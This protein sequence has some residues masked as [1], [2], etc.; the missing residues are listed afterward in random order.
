VIP[1]YVS[2][3]VTHPT[4]PAA[5][6]PDMV[7]SAMRVW[8]RAD[9][10]IRFE[11]LGTTQALPGLPFDGKNVIGYGA[12]L[13]PALVAG[14]TPT[15]F[16]QAGD[17]NEADIV[18]SPTSPW[19]WQSC[20]QQDGGCAG[21]SADFMAGPVDTNTWGPEIQG[22]VEHELGHMLGLDHPDELGGTEETMFSTLSSDNL[23][24]QTL[25]L[26][27]ILGVRAIYPCGKL[28][29]PPVVYAP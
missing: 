5:S 22:M 11:Y 4:V 25:G 10:L 28:C 3:A 13:A 26:G 20:P 15:S 9:P 2:V 21:H 18:I 1:Y 19:T 12:P 7:A 23:T 17:I 6:L 16:T 29:E 27:D 8:E 14:Y 24:P